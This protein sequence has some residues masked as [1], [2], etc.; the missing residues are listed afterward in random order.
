MFEPGQEV[1]FSYIFDHAIHAAFA[2]FFEDFVVRYRFSDHGL[3]PATLLFSSANQF[4][5]TLS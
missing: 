5:T 1:N 2:E 3:P 4:V